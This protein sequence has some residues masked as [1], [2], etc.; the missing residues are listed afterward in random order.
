M[1]LYEYK[2]QKCGKTFEIIQ[3]LSDKPAKKCINCGG[4]V[5]KLISPSALQFKGEG[6]YITDYARKKKPE[7]KEKPKSKKKPEKKESK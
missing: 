3:K 5:K 1:P 4:L 2:C 6:W 7:K